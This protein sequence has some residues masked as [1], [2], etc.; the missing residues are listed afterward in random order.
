[1]DPGPEL[2]LEG[3]LQMLSSEPP[4]IRME[5]TGPRKSQGLAQ[6]TQPP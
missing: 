3:H 6:T 1:M 5:R 4:M 2:E